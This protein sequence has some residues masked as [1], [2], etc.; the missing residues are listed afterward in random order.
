M[1]GATARLNPA[2]RA[3]II[4]L[5][6][7]GT[8]GGVGFLLDSATVYASRATLG[9]YGAGVLAYFVAATGNWLLN[10]VW[11]FRGRGSGPAHRQWAAFLAANLVGFVLNRGTYAILVTV[12]ALCARQPVYAIA[13]GAIAG[14][15]TNFS[16][17]RKLVFK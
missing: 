15:F 7:F 12:S 4:D 13:A 1:I 6:R 9:L 16:L 8:V 17:S 14:L 5:L 3:W 10:R 11:T 2:R